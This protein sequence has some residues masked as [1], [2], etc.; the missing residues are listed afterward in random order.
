M[1]GTLL[2][3][4][5]KK[6]RDQYDKEKRREVLDASKPA[7]FHRGAYHRDMEG[8]TESTWYDA[9]GHPHIRRIYTQGYYVP[10]ISR[11]QQIFRR[12]FYVLFFAAGVF[13]FGLGTT[14]DLPANH[15]RAAAALQVLSVL[16]FLYLAGLL[17]FYCVSFGKMTVGDFKTIHKPLVVASLIQAMLLWSGAIVSFFINL[18][19]AS[20]LSHLHYLCPLAEAS[21]GFLIFAV[22]LMEGRLEYTVEHNK[23][24]DTAADGVEIE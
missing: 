3:P 9:K 24:A 14:R 6:L 8:Y 13:L 12:V 10:A 1:S 20:R 15:N 21:A 22:F 16:A 11:R 17:I 19:Q 2:E 5:K 7:S 4:L 18:L 23:N